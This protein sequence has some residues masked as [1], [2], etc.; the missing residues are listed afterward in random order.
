MLS[1]ELHPTG[2]KGGILADKMGLGKTVQLLACMSQNPP[3]KKKSNKATK[4]LIIAR[5]TLIPQWYKEIMSHCSQKK[6]KNVFVYTGGRIMMPNQFED[7][8]IV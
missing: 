2:P 4:T 8:N 1:R 5:K 6:M 7:A 3:R